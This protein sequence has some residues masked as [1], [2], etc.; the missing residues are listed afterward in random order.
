M[1]SR[2]CL[3]RSRILGL[4]LALLFAAS[5]RVHA[6]PP[7]EAA[8]LVR[9]P[10]PHDDGTLTP[11]TFE[12]GYPLLT[13]VYDTLLWR[14][15]E[16]LPRPWL[17]RSV[18]TT[19]DGRTLSIRLAEGVRWHDGAPLS[20]ADVAFTFRFV[21]ERFHPRFTPQLQ[22]VERVEAPDPSTVV[23]VLRHP[24]PGFLD[25]PLADLPILPA[26]IWESLPRSKL[27]PDGLPVGTGPYRLVEH[28]PGKGYRFEA[29]AG[30]F[31]GRPAVT[32]IEVPI[33]GA[34][35]ETLEALDEGRVDVVPV[36]LPRDT[37][38]RFDGLGTRVLEGPSYLGT[39]LVFNVRRP[40][41][42]QLAVR[43]AVAAA[44]DL[45]RMF[46]PGDGVPADRGYLHP[47]SPWSS[48]EA[49]H[50]FDERA[51]QAAVT[52]FGLP[53]IVVLAPENDPVKLE[54]GRQVALALRR[55]GAVAEVRATGR[56]ELS[57]A[58][59][60]DGSPPT[61]EAAILAS[62]ALATYDPDFLRPLF[63]SDPTQAPL[64]H[65]GYRS[66]AFDD[67]AQQ[68]AATRDPDARQ[69]AVVEALRL[70]ANDVP[71]VPLFFATG[72]YAYRPAGYDGWRFVKG[73]GILDK[74]SFVEPRAAPLRPPPTSGRRPADGLPFGSIALGA[75]G[76]A[77]VLIVVG[78]VRRRG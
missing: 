22:A 21:A 15:E 52:S 3:A 13:L 75:L 33:I 14:D 49:L 6:Q 67:L 59:G 74:R 66:Q 37:A 16:G 72:R 45:N 61:F 56:E 58:V 7:S 64:N 19:A 30:Y 43:R 76:A 54:A 18:E 65:A 60:E 38:A 40:P 28:Q 2:T 55:A 39:V 20:A 77:A 8:P 25:Q 26:H 41:F 48:D 23:I 78:V 63:G 73:S 24:S 42:D 53:P 36:T 5:P 62:P 1:V 46:R 69:V 32:R 10:F 27:A 44:L 4:A 31:L 29:N 11:Y 9:L 50:T 57:R 17:G 34:F 70:L 35:E 68:I 47:A 71:V 51:A 12:L